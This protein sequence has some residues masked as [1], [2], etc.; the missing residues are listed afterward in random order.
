MDVKGAWL[1]WIANYEA[2]DADGTGQDPGQRVSPRRKDSFWE[3]PGGGNNCTGTGYGTASLSGGTFVRRR[4]AG[5]DKHG[6]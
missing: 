2:G 1:G 6:L 5:P 3:E 4:P